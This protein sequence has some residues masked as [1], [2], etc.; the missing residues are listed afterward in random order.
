MEN[1]NERGLKFSK[2]IEKFN[3]KLITS[4]KLRL[5]KEPPLSQSGSQASPT[6]TATSSDVPG[7]CPTTVGKFNQIFSKEAHQNL[8]LGSKNEKLTVDETI[9]IDVP[10]HVYRGSLTTEKLIF[11]KTMSP[12]K[13]FYKETFLNRI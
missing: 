3:E 4:I 1:T 5:D 9:P 7:L 10:V 13:N 6:V 11:Y 2:I 8:V 12:G